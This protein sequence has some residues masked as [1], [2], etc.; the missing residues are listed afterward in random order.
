MEAPD[1][2][3]A[4]LERPTGTRTRTE[5]DLLV[6]DMQHLTAFTGKVQ[7]MSVWR[8]EVVMVYSA[9]VLAPCGVPRTTQFLF[10]ERAP[11]LMTFAKRKCLRCFHLHMS[12]FAISPMAAVTLF[13]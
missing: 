5:V 9:L 8:G 7:S 4:A 2:V 11:F 10:G 1:P 3:R 13:C 6:D 12:V